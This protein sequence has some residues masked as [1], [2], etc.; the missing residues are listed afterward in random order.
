MSKPRNGAVRTPDQL[1]A[2]EVRAEMA[3]Q[4]VSQTKLAREVFQ[5]YPQFIQARCSGAVPFTAVELLKVADYL[6]VDV[7]QFLSA[8]HKKPPSGGDRLAP[9]TTSSGWSRADQIKTIQ[10]LSH[11]ATALG[12]AA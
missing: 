9:V 3:R 10:E 4:R 12:L 6:D 1:I 11:S 2:A 8:T 5:A 7:V